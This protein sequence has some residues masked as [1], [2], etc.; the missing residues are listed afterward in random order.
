MRPS[1]RDRRRPALLALCLALILICIP[2]AA[3]EATFRVLPGGSAYEASV[4]VTASGYTFWSPGFLGE[5]VPL[6]VEDIE[7]LG[8]EGPV[9]YRDRGRGAITFPEGD[10]TISYRAPLRDNHFVVVFDT[11]YTVSLTLPPGL[12]VKN[13]L[14]G[15]VSRGAVI[16]REPDEPLEITWERASSVEVRFYTPERELL[17]TTFGT[18]WAAIAIVLL[19]PFA[20]SWRRN[21]R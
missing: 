13:P 16:S 17:L 6:K 18:I 2:V 8:P 10:Y 3:E 4:Q 12:D 14:L 20:A 7:V 15:M 11:P 1:N 19:L 5:Q 21:R 9:E